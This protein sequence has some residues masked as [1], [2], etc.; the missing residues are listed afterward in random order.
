MKY[1]VFATALIYAVSAMEHAVH[2]VDGFTEN[3]QERER[4]LHKHQSIV[5]LSH[6]REVD[7]LARPVIGVLSEPVRGDL[8]VPGT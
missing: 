6:K 7:H 2:D 5:N 3:W 1:I 8:F 4:T